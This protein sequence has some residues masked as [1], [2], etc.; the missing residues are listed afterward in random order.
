MRGALERI[1]EI[2]ARAVAGSLV[3]S[4]SSVPMNT[5]E[6]KIVIEAALLCARQPLSVAELRTMFDEEIA[7]ETVRALLE[8][9]RD[10]WQGRG[11]ELVSLA[12]GWRFQSTSRMAPYLD[13]LHPEKPPRYSRALME[14]L[15]IIAY[16]QPVTRGDIEE[17]RGVS[18]AS[19]LVK[20]LED[21]G[22]VEVIGHKDVIGR[23]ELLGTT[24]QFLDDLGLRSLGELPPLLEPGQTPGAVEA[25]AQRVIAFA[26]DG[27]QDAMLQAGDAEDDSGIATR[28]VSV[29]G[30]A[31]DADEGDVEALAASGAVESEAVEALAIA[32]Q[33]EAQAAE[34]GLAE[35]AGSDAI[36]ESPDPGEHT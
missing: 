26:G 7:S 30:P 33:I 22:W 6:A 28:A 23:P 34:A 31:G 29:A 11:V 16:R 10:D 35:Q 17:I 15:A 4:L 9:L 13:R 8:D 14:T 32:D 19:Q 20:T 21:R 1:L 27:A 24:R 2:R 12:T 18:V 5:E 36:P 25:I 3:C